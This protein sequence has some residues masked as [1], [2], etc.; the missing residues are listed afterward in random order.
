[1]PDAE[2]VLQCCDGAGPKYTQT[3]QTEA[4]VSKASSPRED[5]LLAATVREL[6]PINPTLCCF[7]SNQEGSSKNLPGR[8]ETSW[9]TRLRKSHLKINRQTIKSTNSLPGWSWEGAWLQLCATAPSCFPMLG[10]DICAE[11]GALAQRAI[12]CLYPLPQSVSGMQLAHPSL[13][14]GCGLQPPVLLL[15]L[16]LFCE[17]R[18]PQSYSA[19]QA[20]DF[21]AA[22][23]MVGCMNTVGVCC[24]LQHL[25]DGQSRDPT[26][27][28]AQIG[29][30]SPAPFILGWW[31]VQSSRRKL[32]A[33][34]ALVL[35][36][37][38]SHYFSVLWGE[39]E[40]M[41]KL[42]NNCSRFWVS[43]IRCWL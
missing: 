36:V 33:T 27:Q 32:S 23:A 6:L 1:M 5:A 20:G 22:L 30:L 28:T 14:P 29:Y 41:Q 15:G 42:I 12:T 9:V 43:Y 21:T 40:G 39:S 11:N 38:L 10:M 35:S 31:W 37:D 18:K 19:V 8:L 2:C 26:V 3:S 25:C 34:T 4:A 7:A 17:H 13:P 16:A 24:V